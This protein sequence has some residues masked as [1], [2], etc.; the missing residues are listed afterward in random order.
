MTP[1][2]H[3]LTWFVMLLPM[4]F[5]GCG[6]NS[7]GRPTTSAVS[8]D[9]TSAPTRESFT[10]Y[11][12]LKGYP[13]REVP[14]DSNYIE[15]FFEVGPKYEFAIGVNIL[16]SPQERAE[17]QQRVYKI[18]NHEHKGVVLWFWNIDTNG[19]PGYA[20]FFEKLK[21]V[22]EGYDPDSFS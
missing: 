13:L 9:S 4:T 8:S 7:R 19:T 18:P 5:I 15:Y 17:F 21:G 22:V 11:L 6:P 12:A 1:L 10:A 14:C 20:K 16:E 3:L 2:H